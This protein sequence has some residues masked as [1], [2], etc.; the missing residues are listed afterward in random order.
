MLVSRCSKLALLVELSSL[1]SS[2]VVCGFRYAAEVL[3][4]SIMENLRSGL[5]E[6]IFGL[7]EAL[8]LSA[9]VLDEFIGQALAS[10]DVGMHL[11]AFIAEGFLNLCF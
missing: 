5:E 4:S 6:R 7:G 1:S 9:C 3:I 10:K 8:D 11:F 2:V